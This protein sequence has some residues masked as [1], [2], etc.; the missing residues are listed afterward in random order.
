MS[1]PTSLISPKTKLARMTTLVVSL[2]TMM[3][4]LDVFG[5]SLFIVL[6]SFEF[7][8]LIPV[9]YSQ[10]DHHPFGNDVKDVMLALRCVFWSVICIF[11]F[12]MSIFFNPIDAFDV[13]V[14][15]FN[16]MFTTMNLPFTLLG[17]HLI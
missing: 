2:I 14:K 6:L 13:S 9:H 5:E 8:W 7:L 11:V 10:N 3:I 1:L 4:V 16:I 15:S 17:K 12:D